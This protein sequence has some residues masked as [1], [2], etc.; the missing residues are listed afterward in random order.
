MSMFSNVNP[1]NPFSWLSIPVNILNGIMGAG[2]GIF[3]AGQQPAQPQTM[4]QGFQSPNFFAHTYSQPIAQTTPQGGFLGN[5][6]RGIFG[7]IF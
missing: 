5:I 7:G 2:S 3:G 4:H 6:V 1:L